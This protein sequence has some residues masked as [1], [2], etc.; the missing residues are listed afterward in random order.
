M[1]RHVLLSVV[2]AAAAPLAVDIEPQ[3]RDS[4]VTS[5]SFGAGAASYAFVTRGCDNSV[6]SAD[7]RYFHDAGISIDHKFSSPD[8][9]GLRVVMLDDLDPPAHPLERKLLWNPYV[10]MDRKKISMGFGY[11]FRSEVFNELTD[12]FNVAKV[13]G[14]VRFGNPD[15]V[16]VAIRVFEDIPPYSGSGAG[17][18][19]LELRPARAWR[20]MLGAG[21]PDPYDNVGFVTKSRIGLTRSI[22]VDIGG[23]I[24]GSQGLGEMGINAGLTYSWIHGGTR[25]PD[26]VD[27]TSGPAGN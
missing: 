13:S 9:V 14:H 24:G 20:L 26:H 4:S 10:S 3:Q 12:D 17:T 23:R 21:L 6:L 16:A 2:V 18:I 1:K 8:R 22:S 15:K 19:G 5:I 7:Q 27:S 11:V 25:Q